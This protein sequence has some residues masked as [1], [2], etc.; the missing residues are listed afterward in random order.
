MRVQKKKSVGNNKWVENIC[1]KPISKRILQNTYSEG[2]VNINAKF[3]RMN[4]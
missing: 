4:Y 1:Q 2:Y 3:W